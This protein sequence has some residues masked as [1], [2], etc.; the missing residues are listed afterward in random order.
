M[1][2]FCQI[3]AS[4]REVFKD[5]FQQNQIILEYNYLSPL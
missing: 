3:V 5:Q 4:Y 1:F 2:L